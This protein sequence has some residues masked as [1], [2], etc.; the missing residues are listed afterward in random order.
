MSE[1]NTTAPLSP[2]A[3]ELLELKKQAEALGISVHP[4]AK[5]QTIRDKIAAHEANAIASEEPTET[6]VSAPQAR[7]QRTARAIR[8]EAF[9]L[10]RCK[11]SCMNPLK[12]EWESEPFTFGNSVIGSQTRVIPYDQ[13]WH[14]PRMLLN[15][16]ENRKYQAFRTKRNP[17]TGIKYRQGYLAKEYVIEILPSLNEEELKELARRQAV[18]QGQTD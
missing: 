13:E 6:T 7:S 11:I 18:E 3:E 2:E 17:Q 12:R 5:A 14:V 8:D 15:L 16:L 4:A 1:Q 9:Q 10:I